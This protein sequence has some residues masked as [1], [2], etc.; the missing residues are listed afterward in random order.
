MRKAEIVDVSR[1]AESQ[2]GLEA[3]NRELETQI[4][5][6]SLRAEASE[7]RVLEIEENLSE[8]AAAYEEKE[9]EAAD[10]LTRGLLERLRALEAT[11][12]TRTA[13]A[14]YSGGGTAPAPN[15]PHNFGNE[16]SIV[17]NTK[18]DFD[19][20]RGLSLSDLNITTSISTKEL[21]RGMASNPLE[22]T[23]PSIALQFVKKVTTMQQ[24]A[25]ECRPWLYLGVGVR[26]RFHDYLTEQLGIELNPSLP[27]DYYY[28]AA[29]GADFCAD[30]LSFI[31]H[32]N[33]IDDA[34][35]L[36]L[37]TMDIHKPFVGHESKDYI[38]LFTIEVKRMDKIDQQEAATIFLEGINAE[39]RNL[40][41]K[42]FPF[43]V[44]S[45][46]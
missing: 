46:F 27:F 12:N 1:A 41:L 22:T 44:S 30:L 40:L 8:N 43:L 19:T 35:F 38:S 7:N 26:A 31:K 15:S 36:K 33:G 37:L 45:S 29:T 9:R 25:T 6:A 21:E 14:P 10:R 13:L 16:S 34:E 5:E 32:D 20:T 23:N 17:G 24:L 11:V 4:F 39:V 42:Q 3:H 2:H 28:N 18:V